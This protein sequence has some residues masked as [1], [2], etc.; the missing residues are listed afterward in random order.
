MY[1]YQLYFDLKNGEN[2]NMNGI[3]LCDE[4][5]LLYYFL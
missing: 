1:I 4:I 5:K 2:S 3:N